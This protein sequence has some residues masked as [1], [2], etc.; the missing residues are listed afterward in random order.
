MR[1]KAA[2]LRPITQ[3]LQVI[4]WAAKAGDLLSVVLSKLCV[5]DLLS[6]MAT[7]TRNCVPCRAAIRTHGLIREKY[8]FDRLR[9]GVDAVALMRRAYHADGFGDKDT[10][11][12]L[13][14]AAHRALPGQSSVWATSITTTRRALL[15]SSLAGTMRKTPLTWGHPRPERLYAV[16]Y[17]VVEFDTDVNPRLLSMGR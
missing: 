14:G 15:A 10:L 2:N 16:H 17:S 3:S 6:L 1:V 7:E 9:P 4:A 11:L 12:Q 8:E 13:D 5:S